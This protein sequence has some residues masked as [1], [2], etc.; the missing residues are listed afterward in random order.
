MATG[1]MPL[2]AENRMQAAMAD[3]PL[4]SNTSD[5]QILDNYMDET[6]E[7]PLQSFEKAKTAVKQSFLGR[8]VGPA[9]ALS[10]FA[11]AASLMPFPAGAYEIPDMGLN[12]SVIT[13]YQDFPTVG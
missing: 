11:A 6:V 1:S 3:V 5:G 10:A 9:F 7:K 4:V 2:M 8:M 13:P 12:P